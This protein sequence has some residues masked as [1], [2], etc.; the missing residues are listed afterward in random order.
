LAGRAVWLVDGDVQGSAQTA[1]GIRSES[2]IQQGYLVPPTLKGLFCVPKSS[3]GKIF[4]NPPQV[5]ADDIRSRFPCSSR[6]PERVVLPSETDDSDWLF[7]QPLG[8]I[9]Y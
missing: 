7:L 9:H 4:D 5:K 2:D 8:S 3:D 1:L 6:R